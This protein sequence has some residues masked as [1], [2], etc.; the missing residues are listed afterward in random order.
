MTWVALLR[1]INLGRNKRLAMADLRRI[2]ETLGFDDVRTHLQ[3]GNA[4]LSTGRTTAAKLEQRIA[5]QL[6]NDVGL[7]VKVLCRTAA[8]LTT[9]VRANPFVARKADPK[10]LHAV[11]LSKTAP[12]KELAA[13]DP[14]KFAPNEFEAGDRVIYLRLPKGVMGGRLPD[15]DRALGLDATMRNWNTVTKLA[16]LTGGGR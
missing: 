3:S 2:L 6:V 15:W 1:G 5:A 7:D 11:F 10:E 9:V 8:Q 13:V 16:D 4:I 12:A 14:E